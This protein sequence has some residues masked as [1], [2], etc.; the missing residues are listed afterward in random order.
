MKKLACICLYLNTYFSITG[1]NSTP[2]KLWYNH[3]AKE[4]TEALPVGNGRVA[5]MVFGQPSTERLQLNECTLWSGGPSRNDN[6]AFL[7]SLPQIR[8]LIFEGK[9]AEAQKIADQTKNM[10]GNNGMKFQPAGNL[11]LHFPGHENAMNYYR[12]LDIERAVESTSYTVD[13]VSFKREVFSSFAD[14]VIIVHLTTDKPGALNFTTWLNSPLKSMTYVENADKLI[15]SGVSST[16]EGVTGEVKFQTHIKIIPEGGSVSSK[17]SVLSVSNANTATI[18]ISIATSYVNYNDATGDPQQLALS[19]LDLAVN[20]NYTRAL[21]NHIDLYQKYFNRIKLDVGETDAMNNP[22]DERIAQFSKTNDPQLVSLY[23]QFGRYLLISSSQPGGQPANLQGIWN[24]QVSPPWDSKYT[25][26]IN[27][28]MNYW[29]SEITNLAELNE[30]LIHMIKDLSETGKETAR[31]MYGA[32]GWVAHHNTDLWRITGPVDKAFYGQWPMGGAWLSQ[33]LWGKYMY[34]GDKDYLQSIY[35]IL[36]GCAEFF[37]TSLVEE[38]EHKWLVVSPSLSP[39]NAPSHHPEASISDGCTM[40]NQLVFD[41]L[42]NTIRAAEILDIDGDFVSLMKETRSRLA[43][44]QIGQYGQLQ[45]WMHD[46]DNPQD[47]HRHVSHLYGLYPSNQISPYRNPELFSAARTSLLYRGD[48]STGWSM[49]WKVN[50]WARLQ[51][52]NHAYKLI[53]DQLSPIGQS[54]HEGGGTYPNLF[55][56]HPPF[57]IDGN[58]GCT[59]GIAEMLMQS[60]D[61]AIHLLPALPDN[62]KTGNVE[63]LRA[64]GGFEIVSMIWANGKLVRF[65][66]KS[67]LGGNCRLRVPNPLKAEGGVTLKKALGYNPNLFYQPFEIKTPLISTNAVLQKTELKTTFLYDFDTKPGQTY[68]FVAFG[69]GNE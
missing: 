1:Q 38:P 59:A 68:S 37:V 11:Y 9:Y 66:I 56:A 17:D 22:T 24:N 7:D 54:G 25:L 27:T 48:V 29:P 39:E 55:D 26:N 60:H 61:G 35:L 4:W 57:Q 15:L 46:W 52:G 32:R 8:K 65:V 12:E 47:T 13:G 30:P 53:F 67:T 69:Q 20:K 10:V 44:M 19:Y 51:D 62:W 28:E 43:P 36:R 40:D 49:G 14:Q 31:T 50:L 16:H 45:E 6:P 63:G 33:H 64:R 34:S 41:V 58:L 3:P 2:L 21:R 23:F 5:A 18:Y 42:S